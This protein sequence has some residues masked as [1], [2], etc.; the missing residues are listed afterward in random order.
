MPIHH[1]HRVCGNGKSTAS[2]W[3][4]PLPGLPT[5]EMSLMG[6]SGS[7]GPAQI[8]GQD[9]QTLPC[10]SG[11][12]VDL[13]VALSIRSCAGAPRHSCRPAAAPLGAAARL[14]KRAST[15]IGHL[16]PLVRGQVK[17]LGAKA[18]HYVH[19]VTELS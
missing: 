15:D 5:Q 13:A 11:K 17:V 6:A 3:A 16:G 8:Q 19:Q 18:Q 7:E 14:H 2:G 9:P 12:T 4:V 1:A 10:L